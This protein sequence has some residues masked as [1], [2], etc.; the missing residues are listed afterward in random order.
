MS[1]SSYPPLSTLCPLLHKVHGRVLPVKEDDTPSGKTLKEAIVT[2]MHHLYASPTG[3]AFLDPH[4]KDLNP[5]ASETERKD[6]QESVKLEMLDVAVADGNETQLEVDT[7]AQLSNSDS[8][9][10]PHFLRSLNLVLSSNLSGAKAA[11]RKHASGYDRVKS[12]INHYTQEPLLDLD[13]D[14]LEWKSL[15]SVSTM[16]QLVRMY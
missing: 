2:D 3:A 1:A 12:E 16:F 4:F 15:Q 8:Q 6:V 9:E 7:N 13:D 14:P 5:F 11:S 10:S